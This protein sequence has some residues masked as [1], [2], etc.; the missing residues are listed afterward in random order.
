MGLP[1]AA[2]RWTLDEFIAWENQ[3]A[4]RHEFI[5]GEILAMTGARDAHNTIAL[6]VAAA[7]RNHLRGTPCRPYVA[8]MKLRVDA[9]DALFYPD[10]L[11][12]C[13]GRDFTADADLAKRHPKLIVEVLSGSTGAYDRGEK[14]RAYRQIDTLEEYVLIEQHVV[15]VDV[16]RKDGGGHWVLYPFGHSETPELASVGLR[17]PMASIYEDVDFERGPAS[18]AAE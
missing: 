7:L 15:G 8:D 1:Q 5:A 17:L 16:F 13:D 9:A 3:Q 11:V 6:N 12:T 14:F 4:E 10:I 18:R 2:R